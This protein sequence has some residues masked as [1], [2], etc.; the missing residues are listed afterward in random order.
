MAQAAQQPT[1]DTADRSWMVWTLVGMAAIW[2]GV[3]AIS[4]TAPDLVSGSQQEHLPLAAFLTWIWGL[5]ASVGFLWGMSR[6]R[7]DARRRSLWVGLTIA[8]AI[9]WSVA[10]VLSAALPVWEVGSDPTRL[11]LWALVTPLGAALLTAL[12]AVVAGLFSESPTGR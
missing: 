5:I 3:V 2:I 8:I 11:P 7:G 4:V 9:I 1:W 12:A 10:T 6:L